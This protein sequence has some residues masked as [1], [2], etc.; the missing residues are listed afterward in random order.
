MHSAASLLVG[1]ASALIRRL[2]RHP[3]PQMS[4]LAGCSVRWLWA[5]KNSG[6]QCRHALSATAIRTADEHTEKGMSGQMRCAVHRRL[7][8]QL[9]RRDRHMRRRRKRTPGRRDCRILS[10]GNPLPQRPRFRE[11]ASS[12]RSNV[13]WECTRSAT[14]SLPPQ[15]LPRAP[16]GT[17]SKDRVSETH[18]YRSLQR[19][20]GI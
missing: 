16:P 3:L 20:R 4:L 14:T 5:A 19:V 10:T 13:V 12:L 17:Q 11:P 9:L 6:C 18:I 8:F 15:P 2:Q 7:Q 1:I